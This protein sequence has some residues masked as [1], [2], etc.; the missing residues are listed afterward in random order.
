MFDKTFT[1]V[2]TDQSVSIELTGGSEGLKGNEI[3]VI[4]GSRRQPIDKQ[5]FMDI[6]A[7]AL[8]T[9]VENLSI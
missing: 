3:W 4:V 7:P 8:K 1:L 5:T 9:S 2:S 6:I